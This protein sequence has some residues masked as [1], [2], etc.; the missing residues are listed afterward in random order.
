M[1]SCF[2]SCLLGFSCFIDV[3]LGV[4]F[5]KVAPLRGVPIVIILIA[6]GFIT[7]IFVGGNKKALKYPLETSNFVLEDVP[8]IEKGCAPGSDLG[9]ASIDSEVEICVE[10]TRLNYRDNQESNGRGIFV[11]LARFNK[12]KEVYKKAT[13]SF[14]RNSSTEGIYLTGEPWEMA[15]WSGSFFIIFQEYI[16]ED[17]SNGLQ[18]SYKTTLTLEHPIIKWFLEEYPPMD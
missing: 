5:S 6:I 8:S 1:D 14:L 3:I 13:F 7:Y 10:G 15:W 17:S 4:N 11:D 12:G 2:I 18:Y 16:Q 9:P